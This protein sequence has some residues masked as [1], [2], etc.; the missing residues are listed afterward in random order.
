[1]EL[2]IVAAGRWPVMILPPARAKVGALLAPLLGRT[3]P[4][5]RN[6]WR[7]RDDRHVDRRNQGVR[8]GKGLRIVQA[9]LSG[10]R[11]RAR[12]VVGRPRLSAPR[13]V[14]L[15]AAELLRRG[16]R[17][18]F[19]DAP[20]GERR[21]GLVAPRSGPRDRRQVWRARAAAGG[22]VVGPARLPDR[23]PDRG[24]VAHRPE[25]RAA[26][27]TATSTWP[28]KAE[29]SALWRAL[30][31]H[32][33]HVPA[34]T[35]SLTSGMASPRICSSWRGGTLGP[36]PALTTQSTTA[37]PSPA[38][39]WVIPAASMWGLWGGKPCPPQARA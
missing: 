34:T 8:A 17:R 33:P 1:M 23:R 25:H 39:A 2:E 27:L 26:R 32:A 38:G 20:A 15:P 10:P 9:V 11:L 18:Q 21:G 31:G 14:E 7:A 19:H 5:P 29:A 16:A 6:R 3:F 13:H 35:A 4:T 36:S 24:A 30:L 12:L 28:G 37:A 22:P